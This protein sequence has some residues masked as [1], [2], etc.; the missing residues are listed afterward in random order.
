MRYYRFI[1]LIL[2]QFFFAGILQTAL[3][4][5]AVQLHNFSYVAPVK[6]TRQMYVSEN[7]VTWKS[8]V[9]SR[10]DKGMNMIQ[11]NYVHVADTAQLHLIDQAKETIGKGAQLVDEAMT[12][13]ETKYGKPKE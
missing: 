7:L 2:P 11:E 13:L 10:I 8:F 1:D 12:Y 3:F 4:F 9:N 6:R 5:E